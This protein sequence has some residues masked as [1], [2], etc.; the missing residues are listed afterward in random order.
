MIRKAVIIASPLTKGQRGYLPGVEM[1]VH[2]Y[3]T[4]LT[5]PVGGS[6]LPNEIQVLWNP[7]TA[8]VKQTMNAAKADY[9]FTAYSG[10]GG[11]DRKTR[12]E[13]LQ[14]NA[15]EA[16]WLT[17]LNAT[18]S[19][20]Q[21]AV[22]DAC[23]TVLD[24]GLSGFAGPEPISFT[25]YLNSSKARQLF[26][27]RVMSSEHGWT[28]IH[29]ASPGQPSID[30]EEGGFFS[31]SL[32]QSVSNWG[33]KYEANSILPTRVAYQHSYHYLKNVFKAN[34]T[35]RIWHSESSPNFPFALRYGTEL[36]R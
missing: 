22:I 17:Y 3:T 11:T 20:R 2:N 6:W 34:Q 24:S 30:T 5:S 31:R 16:V 9:V 14:I 26:D 12:K 1:D 13:F 4:F 10:H 27:Y 36:P 7:S 35:P 25:S 18:G 8:K 21:L 23:S 29:S 33:K 28:V 32:L 19:K 15:T